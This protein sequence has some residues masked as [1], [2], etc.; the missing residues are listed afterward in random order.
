MLDILR[1]RAQSWM[2]L[3]I[4]G[5]VILVFI[6]FFGFGDMRG[7]LGLGHRNGTVAKVD[8]RPILAGA[9]QL[10]V[11]NN[12]AFYQ[13][14]FKNEIP[15][16]I[17]KGIRPGTLQQLINQQLLVNA[18]TRM[19]LR[20]SKEELADKI[21]TFPYLQKDGNFELTYYKEVFLGQLHRRYGIDFE[22]MIADELLVEKFQ[23]LLKSSVG[24]PPS[25][26]RDAYDRENTQWTFAT[27]ELDL[28]ALVAA[29]KIGDRAEGERIA[30]ELQAGFAQPAARERLLKTY[31][32]AE[33]KVGPLPLHARTQLFGPEAAQETY[34]TVFALTKER[35]VP[36]V[37]LTVG[38]KMVVVRLE[39]IERPVEETWK[40]EGPHFTERFRQEKANARVQQWLASLTATAKIRRYLA[41]E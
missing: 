32:L 10:A 18:A 13:E 33:K 29:K 1:K 22:R 27:V 17:A 9:F 40:K 39:R 14:M 7:D 20:V 11:E 35:P 23:T 30:A 2:T 4:F 6:F 16:P 24:A 5:V 8:G 34:Q 15:E 12:T 28:D 19:G 26:V 41:D 38:K 37:P 3:L 25:E 31:G 36:P 21:R